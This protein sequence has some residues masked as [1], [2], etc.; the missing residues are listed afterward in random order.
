MF[1]EMHSAVFKAFKAISTQVNGRT[2]AMPDA[3]ADFIDGLVTRAQREGVL[4][5]PIYGALRSRQVGTEMLQAEGF[6]KQTN[7]KIEDV[8]QRE[9]TIYVFKSEFLNSNGKLTSTEPLISALIFIN[10]DSHP[11]CNSQLGETF[12]DKD[13]HELLGKGDKNKGKR[14]DLISTT[15]NNSLNFSKGNSTGRCSLLYSKERVD[16]ARKL[17]SHKTLDP[18]DTLNQFELMG[19]ADPSAHGRAGFIDWVLNVALEAVN[20]DTFNAKQIGLSS[21]D[22]LLRLFNNIKSLTNIIVD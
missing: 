21:Y 14:F 10:T 7:L 11:W 4:K 18:I 8:V 17:I 2:D 19:L 15:I 3:I 22:D 16:L 20:G 9:G 1:T 13:L 5:Q 6:A 12:E